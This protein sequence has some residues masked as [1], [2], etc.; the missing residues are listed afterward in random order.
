[1]RTT[2]ANP[3]GIDRH[4]AVIKDRAFIN[5]PD[6]IKTTKKKNSRPENLK[7]C[8]VVK[9]WE[10]YKNNRGDEAIRRMIVS[11]IKEEPAFTDYVRQCLIIQLALGWEIEDMN[12]ED[13]V[14][15]STKELEILDDADVFRGFYFPDN[16]TL[17]PLALLHL[18]NIWTDTFTNTQSGLASKLIQDRSRQRVMRKITDTARAQKCSES[19][20]SDLFQ[21]LF[22]VR[23]QDIP[24]MR[25]LSRSDLQEVNVAFSSIIESI[26][27][28]NGYH[29][30]YNVRLLLTSLWYLAYE[31]LQNDPGTPPFDANV[32]ERRKNALIRKAND[33]KFI[34][35]LYTDSSGLYLGEKALIIHRWCTTFDFSEFRNLLRVKGGSPEN[36]RKR[37]Y[38]ASE[39]DVM[40]S[41]MIETMQTPTDVIDH[42]TVDENV[43]SAADQNAKNLV[44][45]SVPEQSMV[46]IMDMELPMNED[47]PELLDT[48]CKTML[49]LMHKVHVCG[50]INAKPHEEIKATLDTLREPACSSSI[51]FSEKNEGVDLISR[52][53]DPLIALG[54]PVNVLLSSLLAGFKNIS[55][56][57]I[58]FVT[59]IA[60]EFI[61]RETAAKLSNY[62]LNWDVAL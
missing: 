46:D 18:E 40:S 13:E 24:D 30:S 32:L 25:Y 17:S 57:K 33:E 51:R 48:M 4:F 9:L 2:R 28:A 12:I 43:P 61:I 6:Q 38:L 23:R 16:I 8:E 1:M 11:S 3:D 34:E 35:R 52:W 15:R 21:R 37:K 10:K 14:E 44:V 59:D 62:N 50:N 56:F 19:Q 54:D 60:E 49:E 22:E 31:V 58:T 26:R 47:L 42:D 41:A 53:P 29:L 36:L 27:E 20:G 5:K 7:K 39:K 45:Q 55:I